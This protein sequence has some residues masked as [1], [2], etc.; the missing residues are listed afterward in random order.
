MQG[1]HCHRL[2]NSQCDVSLISPTFNHNEVIGFSLKIF[3]ANSDMVVI[4]IVSNC[5]LSKQVKPHIDN[6]LTTQY[7]GYDLC[8]FQAVKHKLEHFSFPYGL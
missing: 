1:Q 4:C 2:L 3:T 8:V 7:C 6:N 5:R